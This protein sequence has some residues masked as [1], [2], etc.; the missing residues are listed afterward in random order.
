MV[1]SSSS[2]SLPT[3]SFLLMA[4]PFPV[5]LMERF[6]LPGVPFLPLSIKIAFFF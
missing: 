1:I 4:L 5:S 3:F 2:V 6:A